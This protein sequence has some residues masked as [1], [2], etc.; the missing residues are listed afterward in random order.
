MENIKANGGKT[1]K[2]EMQMFKADTHVLAEYCVWDCVLTRKLFDLFEQKLKEEGLMDLFYKDEIMPLYRE[3][4]IDMKRKGFK[5]DMPYFEKLK[6]KIEADISELQRQCLESI[7]EY[8][9]EYE[10]QCLDEEFPISRAG[11]YPKIAAQVYGID[12]PRNKDGNITTAKK[13]LLKKRAEA[14]EAHEVFFLDWMLHPETPFPFDSVKVQRVMYFLKRPN[15][16]AV[17][18]LQSNDDLGWLFFKK[19]GE[20][21]LGKTD[22]G[23]PKCDDDYLESIKDRYEWVAKLIDLKKLQKLASTYIDGIL[24]RQVDGVLYSSMLQFGTTSGRFSS[25]D[26]NLQNIP[27]VKDE[28]ADLSEIVLE[29]TNG[30]K[31]GFIAPD[32]YVILNADYSQLEPI[33]FAHMSGDEKLRDVFRK[34]HDLYSTIAIDVFGLEGYSADKKAPNYLGKHRKEFRQKAK[35]FCLAVVYG[36]EAGRIS[37]S[38]DMEYQA[39]AEIIDAYLDAYPELRNYMKR[40]D[41]LAM[42]RGIARTEFGRVRHIP[43]AKDIYSRWGDKLLYN[44]RWVKDQGLEDTRY[45]LKNAL[46]NSKNFPIQGL[47]AHIV[48]RSMIATAR[49]FK[50]NGIDGWICMQVHDELTC[51][52]RR[53][54]ADRAKVI[55]RDCMENTTR[56]SVPLTAEPM[57]AETWAD[58]K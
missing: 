13:E 34:N 29:Y 33:C 32:G 31:C 49:A 43:H 50:Q 42:K 22:G 11:S 55:L 56:I 48:N 3:V 8:V 35:M 24:D 10:T 1:T 20:T 12:L 45:K 16:N 54:Q 47:A 5:V 58:A 19:L 30:I 14:K 7:K 25:R 38:L 57:I 23:K 37:K 18:N 27:R 26:P 21:P 17:F 15:D 4:T 9:S 46:N 28:E 41:Y 36:A 40:C 44:N 6:V 2:E 51:M 53:D 39:A 52:V